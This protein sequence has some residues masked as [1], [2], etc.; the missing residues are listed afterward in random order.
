[1]PMKQLNL[2][3]F[4]FYYP[5][6]FSLKKYKMDYETKYYRQICQCGGRIV[7]FD[8]LEHTYTCN[9]CRKK[10]FN[11]EVEAVLGDNFL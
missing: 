6:R 8:R 10:L 4:I 3:D 5:S 7:T 1:M 2:K 9:T 11:A